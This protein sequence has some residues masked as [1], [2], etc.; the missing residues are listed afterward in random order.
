MSLLTVLFLSLILQEFILVIV[1][2]YQYELIDSISYEL[3]V[4][5]RYKKMYI[6]TI[7]NVG[8]AKDEKNEV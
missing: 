1:I 8:I 7:N 5:K 2:I 4:C 6:D 3:K